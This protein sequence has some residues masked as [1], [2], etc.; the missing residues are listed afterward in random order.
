M[1][2]FD[3][4]RDLQRFA[5]KYNLSDFTECY[6]FYYRIQTAN[7]SNTRK[8]IT[9]L[10][11]GICEYNFQCDNELEVFRAELDCRFQP[12][13]NKNDKLKDFVREMK[14][15]LNEFGYG[16]ETK[17]NGAILHYRHEGDVSTEIILERKKKIYGDCL[18]SGKGCLSYS[19][20]KY[21]PPFEIPTSHEG[22]LYEFYLEHAYST[23]LK[24]EMSFAESFRVKREH[25]KLNKAVFNFVTKKH[26]LRIP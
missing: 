2:I 1:S 15:S 7:P 5:E 16:F 9:I 24:K 12:L 23:F 8:S 22:E 18:I 26:D 20:S 19:G 4:K 17:V 25:K 13:L 10:C 3:E 11:P 21:I 14:N 6:G